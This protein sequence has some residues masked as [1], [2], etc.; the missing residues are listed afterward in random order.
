MIYAAIIAA[1]AAVIGA[2]IAAGQDAE[3]Q[4]IRSQTAAKYKDLPLPVLDRVVA[5]KLPPDAADRYLKATQ[6]TQ[7]Q[8]DVLAKFMDV[9]NQKGETAEDRAAYLRMQNEAGGIANA[10]QSAVQ[11]GLAARGLAGSG[12]SA[13]LQQQGAQAA[14]N[15]ANAAGVQSAA[16]ARQRYL[17]ALQQS[18]A[19]ASQ[20][21]GQE[22]SAYQAQDAINQ[23]NARQQAEADAR[24]QMLPQQQFDNEMTKLAGEAN[25]NAGVASGYERGAQGT[26]STAAGVGN[27]ATTAG[28]YETKKDAATG[29]ST[30]PE[31]DEFGNPIRRKD[32]WGSA[33]GAP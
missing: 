17:Q 29:E 5:Q 15:A 20:M 16:D 6:S 14:A 1:A 22:L 18:G 19:L 13:A 30:R 3:A 2:L 10:A 24:N 9:V 12:L 26:R 33:G 31:Y 23:F 11:R 28:T 27:A 4:R 8:G 21:R 32:Y 7:A 25:A